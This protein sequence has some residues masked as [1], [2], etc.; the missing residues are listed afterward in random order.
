MKNSYV[1]EDEC[2][3]QTNAHKSPKKLVE[4]AE[5]VSV[6]VESEKNWI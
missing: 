3:V 4:L 6:D 5:K 1:A 2:N